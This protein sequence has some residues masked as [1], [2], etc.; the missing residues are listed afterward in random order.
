MHG[1]SGRV[2]P[3][4]QDEHVNNSRICLISLSS[5]LVSHSEPKRWNFEA[6]GL[7]FSQG[8]RD[9]TTIALIYLNI[10]IS[11]PPTPALAKAGAAPGTTAGVELLLLSF[12]KPLASP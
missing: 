8:K 2:G 1:N 12:P 6:Y 5:A 3:L 7:G 11:Y 10:I 9:P 4:A